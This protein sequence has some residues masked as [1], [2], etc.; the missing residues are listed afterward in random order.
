ML[1]QPWC[2]WKEIN[3]RENCIS[4][5]CYS[6]C[7]APYYYST[8]STVCTY[9][10]TVTSRMDTKLICANETEWVILLHWLAYL[11]ANHV[12]GG[13]KRTISSSTVLNGNCTSKLIDNATSHLVPTATTAK[14]DAKLGDVAISVWRWVIVHISALLVLN[15]RTLTDGC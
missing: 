13:N 14:H 3:K 9:S 2:F 1:D 15:A 11:I 4:S 8:G 6:S 12:N 7:T 5:C 10:A